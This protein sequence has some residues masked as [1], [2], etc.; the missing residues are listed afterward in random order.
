[1]RA[2]RRDFRERGE[3]RDVGPPVARRPSL[4]VGWTCA[5]ESPRPGKDTGL[6]VDQA[7]DRPK[8]STARDSP[9]E[10]V[11]HALGDE[12]ALSPLHKCAPGFTVFGAVGRVF[13]PASCVVDLSS[14]RRPP[15]VSGSATVAGSETAAWTDPAG[16]ETCPIGSETSSTAAGYFRSSDFTAW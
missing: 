2:S 16:W 3:R 13:Q 4:H 12:D 6:S 9:Q 10:R 15:S 1:M 5:V 8:L 7:D 11:R 14:A